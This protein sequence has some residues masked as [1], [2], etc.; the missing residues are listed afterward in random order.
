M[1]DD[2]TQRKYLNDALR[3][4]ALDAVSPVDAIFVGDGGL[5]QISLL[6]AD[7]RRLVLTAADD[8]EVDSVIQWE[9]IYPQPLQ[10]GEFRWVHPTPR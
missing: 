2:G 8:E 6:L 3:G 9:I 1:I 10:I 7:G 4:Q 5:H